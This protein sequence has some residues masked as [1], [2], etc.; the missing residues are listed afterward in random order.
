MSSLPVFD[1]VNATSPAEAMGQLG[2]GWSEAALYA[3]GVDLLDLMKE[4]LY[5]PKKLVNIKTAP[6]LKY[7]KVENGEV[8]IGPL[9]TL[10]EIAAHPELQK[11]H[12]ALARAAGKAATPQI[13]N[14]ATIG[15]NLCQRPRCWYFRSED[16][17]CMRKGG[18]KCFAKEG[19][20]RYHA[21]FTEGEPCVIVHPSAAGVALVAFG[22]QLKIA[23]SSG[24]RTV[25]IEKFFVRPKDNVRRENVLGPKD[26]IT[27]IVI[28][29]S[30]AGMA[31]AYIK[32]REKQSYDWPLADVAVVAK[33][34]G[35]NVEACRIV[36]GSAAPV[37][38]RATE[39]EEFLKGKPLNEENAARAGELA[40]KDASP[41]E[42]N[43]YKVPLFKTVV[44]RTLLALKETK[45][46]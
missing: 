23:S 11:S 15:G 22:A 38:H 1:Y 39:A 8:R 18:E 9:V 4:R 2:A 32:I 43:A 46:S 37:P 21:I 16:F 10:A 28:P 25:D 19:E 40:V 44:R 31:S 5:E 41:L 33:L 17:P 27:E 12:P 26:L 35:A 30:A 36:L 13:R 29:A 7:I 42:Q 24:E 20:N 6:S 14:L 45:A 34:S 3:G